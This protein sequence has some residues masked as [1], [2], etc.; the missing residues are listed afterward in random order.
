M[1]EWHILSINLL[2]HHTQ[3]IEYK[4]GSNSELKLTVESPTPQALIQQLIGRSNL[5]FFLKLDWL[6]PFY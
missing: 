2:V 5:I 4:N 6:S 3:S 1:F